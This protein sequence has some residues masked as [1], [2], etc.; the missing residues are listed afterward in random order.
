MT[1]GP[2]QSRRDQGRTAAP[3]REAVLSALESFTSEAQ[4]WTHIS[5]SQMGVEATWDRPLKTAY[6]AAVP[7][8]IAGAH[9]SLDASA[10]RAAEEATQ[11]LARFD[12]ELGE[13]VTQFAPVF[14]RSESA[15]SSQVE[16]LSA[17]ARAI[18]TAELGAGKEGSN[19][20]RIVSNTNAMTEAL[21]RANDMSVATILALHAVLMEGDVAHTPGKFRDSPVWIGSERDSTPLTAHYVAPN[22]SRVPELMEDL[23]AF[24]DR[25]DISPFTQVVATHAQFENIHPFTDGNGRTGRAIVQA[26]L[27][28][29]GVT[30]QIVVPVSAG[31]L[32]DLDGYHAALDTYREGDLRPLVH[33]FATA[34]VRAVDNSR[35][36]IDDIDDVVN[37]WKANV[38]A[39]SDSHVWRLFDVL[40]RRPVLTAAAAAAELGV[41]APNIY[42]A[43][44]RLEEAGVLQKKSEHRFSGG[45]LYRAD[46]ILEALD[47]FAARAGRREKIQRIKR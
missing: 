32:A 26:Q 44:S 31:L 34:S 36:L 16:Q 29:T 15:S 27:R 46:G 41:K 25:R 22:Y 28:H 38:R 35:V 23:V 33:S 39:R 1:Y 9:L 5:S 37:A 4:E 30:R 24:A 21:E 42:P 47:A 19:A 20:S 8:F 11:E 45:P 40:A 2:A 43:L 7:P 14:L 18:F 13:R 3:T 10:N 12:A 6:Y 17:S